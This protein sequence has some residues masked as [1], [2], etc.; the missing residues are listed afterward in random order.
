MA[1]R[2]SPDDRSGQWWNA[3]LF[4]WWVAANAAAYLI[5]VTGGALLLALTSDATLQAASTNRK[6]TITA[7]AV[8]ASGLYGIV[9][10]QLQWQILIRRMPTLPR[11]KWVVATFVPAFIAMTLVIG[12]EALNTLVSG[13]DPFSVFKNAFVQVFVLGPLI[14]VAQAAALQGQTARWKWWFVGNVTSWLFGAATSEAAAWLLGH[15]ATY[16]GDSTSVTVSPAFPLLAIAF[17]GLWMLWVTA[18]EAT[19]DLAIA[20]PAPVDV[21]PPDAPP[22]FR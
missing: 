13:S 18:P 1:D 4:W 3:R 21:Q 8:V 9:L 10:G 11:R 22:R 20:P 7:V 5:I 17:H 2:T 15:I 19:R 16:P 6:L 14:G 12:P